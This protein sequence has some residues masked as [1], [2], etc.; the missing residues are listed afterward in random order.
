[1]NFEGGIELSMSLYSA[2][3]V[4]RTPGNNDAKLQDPEPALSGMLGF[5][6]PANSGSARPGPVLW[7]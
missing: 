7:T 1:M 6:A 5:G 3:S 2:C 4:T